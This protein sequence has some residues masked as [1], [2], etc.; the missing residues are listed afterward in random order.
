MPA[1]TSGQILA[2]LKVRIEALAPAQRASVDDKYQVVVGVRHSYMG[3]RAVLLTCSPG[4]REQGGRT[5]SDWECAVLVEV[6]YVDSPGAYLRACEDAEQIADDLYTWVTSDAGETLG[7]LKV[8]P[9]LAS[10]VGV[11]GELQVSRSIRF[12]YR[13]LA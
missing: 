3:S 5:C 4:R 2:A 1:V 9:D 10:I 11:E 8:E 7:L 13:G 12:V 6:W